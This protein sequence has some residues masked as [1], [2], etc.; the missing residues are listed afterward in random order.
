[1]DPSPISTISTT[2]LKELK[3]S[4]TTVFKLIS[5]TRSSAQFGTVEVSEIRI[6]E[7]VANSSDNNVCGKKSLAE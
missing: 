2:R 3:T 7:K 6:G 4:S 5:T 1:L